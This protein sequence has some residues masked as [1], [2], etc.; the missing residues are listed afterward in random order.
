MTQPT[1][2]SAGCR[3]NAARAPL[4]CGNDRTGNDRSP[5]GVLVRAGRARQP[6]A[7]ASATLV[8]RGLGHIL[9]TVVPIGACR[10]DGRIGCVA[11]VDRATLTSTVRTLWERDILSGL[12]EL[13]TIPAVSEA[14]DPD[15]A[16]NGHLAAAVEHVRSWLRARELPGAAA[17]V[18]TLDG[19]SPLL[20][21]DVP[22]AD[23]A[24]A[25]AGTVLLYG[26][27]DKQPPVGGW[28]DGLDPW[29]PVVRDGRLY[30]RGAADDGYA[31]FA[32]AAAIEA[33]RAAG[34]R[35]A[36]CVMLLETGEESGSPDMPDYLE[37]L[38]PRLG[39]V[40]LV[41]CLDSGGRRLRAAVADHVAARPGADH[42][43]RAG[44][45][46][47]PALREWPAGRAQFVPGAAACCWTGW[48]T[49]R[50]ARSGCPSC[51]VTDPRTPDQPTRRRRCEAVPGRI[52]TDLGAGPGRR[53]DQRRRA[54]TGAEQHVAPVA[55]GDRRGRPARARRRGQRAAARPPRCA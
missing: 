31:G 11:D 50:P 40:S 10:R 38:A 52:G 32:A 39:D 18:V 25:D 22:A 48:R 42:R 9:V 2:G 51:N 53:A 19:K 8:G 43:D 14:F 16:A 37:L 24:P 29:T 6:V 45:G 41:V 3:Y 28:S 36:R 55:G 7:V 33:V 15:W 30:G 47:R 17:E 35:H 12:S 34:G 13:V 44:A 4:I 27:L 46:E 26:H 20:L 54:G 5:N 21:V 1:A 49:R 23:G